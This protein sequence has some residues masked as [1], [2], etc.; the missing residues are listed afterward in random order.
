MLFA[1]LFSL[2]RSCLSEMGGL[3]RVPGSSLPKR[4]KPSLPRSSCGFQRENVSFRKCKCNQIGSYRG[5]VREK[6]ISTTLHKY[7]IWNIPVHHNQV[8]PPQVTGIYD[9]S[10]CKC[11]LLVVFAVE[12]VSFWKGRSEACSRFYSPKTG[13]TIAS[14]F[15]VWFSERKSLIQEMQV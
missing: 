3:R 7:D 6:Y 2:L 1:C 4:E 10:L 9:F 14:S 11:C 8:S 12:I 13:E 5:T 15:L